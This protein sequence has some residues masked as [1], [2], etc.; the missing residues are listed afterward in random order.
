LALWDGESKSFLAWIIGGEYS[1]IVLEF[2]LKREIFLACLLPEAV[3]DKVYNAFGRYPI[4]F[5]KR[6]MEA[7]FFL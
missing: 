4:S 2:A 7:S 3:A 5:S 6:R 1:V